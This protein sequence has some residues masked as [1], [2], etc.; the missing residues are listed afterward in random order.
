M[1]AGIYNNFIIEQGATFGHVLTWKD[2]SG[3]AI[4]ITGYTARM[5][6]KKNYDASTS[7]IDLTTENGRISLGGAAG[8]ITLTI[9]ASDTDSLT[10]GVYVYDLEM[11][12]GST[13]TRLLQG[14]INVVRQ[15][16]T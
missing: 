9:S 10:Q 14:S 15:V 11:V 5:K 7:L 16:T 12:S 4:N 13:V 8:T 2:S 6:I 1:V 3:T